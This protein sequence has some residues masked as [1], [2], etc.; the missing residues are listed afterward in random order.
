M[1]LSKHNSMITDTV[2]VMSHGQVRGATRRCD[3]GKQ[4]KTSRE[5]EKKKEKIE[6]EVAICIVGS[7]IWPKH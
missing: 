4:R 2:R 3:D 6:G 1:V 7:E 5:V